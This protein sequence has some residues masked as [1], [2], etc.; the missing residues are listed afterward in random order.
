MRRFGNPAHVPVLM[1]HGFRRS[2]WTFLPLLADLSEQYH[3][4]VLDL[5]GHGETAA[6]VPEAAP[7][8]ETFVEAVEVVRAQ[9]GIARWTLL[10]HSMGGTV[11]GLYAARHPERCAGVILL[12]S[13]PKYRGWAKTTDCQDCPALVTDEG[14]AVLNDAVHGAQ[15]YRDIWEEY[16]A[17]DAT[18]LFADRSL[19]V[20]WVMN[21]DDR[22]T[23]AHFERLAADLSPDVMS[24][25]RLETVYRKGHFIHWTATQQVRD[26]IS[27]FLRDVVR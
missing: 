22:I 8:F 7:T 2:G 19:P 4:I 13:T 11:A 12:E 5:P 23:R 18:P 20:L 24:H 9:L 14:I 10:G 16:E 1:I 6:E 27:G 17:A 25:V 15:S 3:L 21:T 26:M